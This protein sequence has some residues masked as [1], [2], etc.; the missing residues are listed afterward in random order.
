MSLPFISPSFG[1]LATL[2]LVLS[3]LRLSAADPVPAPA[4]VTV[5]STAKPTMS[6]APSESQIAQ[7]QPAIGSGL[8]TMMTTELTK[9]P[10]LTVLESIAL[11]DLR[12]ERALGEN[13]EVAA[14]EKVEKGAWK[15]ADYTFKT[16]ITRFGAKE[17][18]FGGGG[19]FIP[20]VGIIPGGFGVKNTESEVQ[21]DWRVID[22]TTRTIAKSGRAVGVEKGSSFAFASLGGGGFS[23]NREFLDSALG[24]ATMKAIALIV[25]DLRGW[26]PPA[27]SGRQDLAASKAKA[28]DEAANAKK[29][30]LKHVKGEVLVVEP[31]Q[32]WISL[33]SEKGFA[34]GDTLKVYKKIEKKNKEGKVVAEDLEPVGT[35]EITKTQKSK[36]CAALQNGITVEEGWVVALSTLDINDLE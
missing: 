19:G 30:S 8:A 14:G 15:G 20:K 16:T 11:N 35:I 18:S 4:P 27:T 34:K 21:I 33:G 36:S 7:W 13:G 29:D 9:L 26:T 24:K 31:G 6:V 25:S 2:A 5:P 3:A 23:N 17:S 32:V 1:K 22:N 10:N 28:A 12:A